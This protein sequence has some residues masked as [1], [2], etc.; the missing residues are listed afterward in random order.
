MSNLRFMVLALLL[1]SVASIKK[2]A[3]VVP[4]WPKL[5]YP[6]STGL[7]ACTGMN[8]CNLYMSGMQVI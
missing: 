8:A 2:K 7:V 3:V 5:P 6:F 1:V 4:G